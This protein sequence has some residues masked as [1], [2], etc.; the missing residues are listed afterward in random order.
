MSAT[1]AAITFAILATVLT[2]GVTAASA[3]WSGEAEFSDEVHVNFN[4]YL[5]VTIENSGARDMTVHT[6]AVLI[7]WPGTPTWSEV[8][9]G[10]EVVSAGQSL[11]FVSEQ[12]RMPDEAEGTY[13]YTVYIDAV[14]ADGQ[15]VQKQFYGTVDATRFTISAF[16]VPEEIFVPAMVTIVPVLATLLIFRLERS[17]EWP[18]LQ[19]VPRFGHR[20]RR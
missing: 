7:S 1:R 5:R 17:K 10:S 4:E 9:S 14:G 19:A 2:L 8:F 16:G 11:E 13:P 15:A 6:V 18:Y 20:S 3:D 12:T